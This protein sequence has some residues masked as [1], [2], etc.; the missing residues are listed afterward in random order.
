MPQ[1]SLGLRFDNNVNS[2]NIRRPSHRHN[3]TIANQ[4][5]TD[6]S[7]SSKGFGGARCSEE[8]PHLIRHVTRVNICD[9]SSQLDLAKT[10]NYGAI[11]TT[12]AEPVTRE[13]ELLFYVVILLINVLRGY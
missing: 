8:E 11:A 5:Q 6:R 13:G 7:S 3:E 4:C 1:V 12:E 9:A 2:D 10:S